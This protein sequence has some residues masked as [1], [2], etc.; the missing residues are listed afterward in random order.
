M[1][2]R[3]FPAWYQTWWFRLAVLLTALLAVYAIVAARTAVLW[4]RQRELESQVV[5]RTAQLQE[6]SRALEEASL[7]DPL[8]GMRNRRFALQHL[9]ND[10]A[11]AIR[12]YEHSRLDAKRAAQYPTDDDLVFYLIDIDH[13]KQVND[14]H[15][16]ASG[17][18]VLAQLPR[19]LKPIFRDTDYLIRWG[20]E[21]FLVVA[22]GTSR[23]GAAEC[24]ERIRQ[25]VADVAFKL[26]GDQPLQ[27]TCSIGF[28]A[29]PFAPSAPRAFGWADT[30]ELAD[31]ALYAAKRA[32]R[33]GWVGLAAGEMAET[34]SLLARFKAAQ[35]GV[36]AQSDMVVTT[37]LPQDQVVAGFAE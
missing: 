6:A 34:E 10:A 26:P 5:A 33:N 13:F 24:A 27:K 15:G 1:P 18:A 37:S 16:H 20:G 32:G 29:F 17:D 22:R 8:T 7:T 14:V 9:D 19:R 4:A 11:T 3:V 35:R 28:A 31:A 23:K 30:V 36:I 21:E 2:I 12:R 25:A